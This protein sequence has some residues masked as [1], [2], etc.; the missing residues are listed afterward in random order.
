M[1]CVTKMAN[2]WQNAVSKCKTLKKKTTKSWRILVIRSLSLS[3]TCFGHSF[4]SRL[5]WQPA[6]CRGRRE[7]RRRGA[8]VDEEK[9]KSSMRCSISLRW[10]GGSISANVIWHS[11]QRRLHG[12]DDSAK[13]CLWRLHAWRCW[14]VIWS[15]HAKRGRLGRVGWQTG[16]SQSAKSDTQ[17]A[18]AEGASAGTTKHLYLLKDSTVAPQPE[19][20]SSRVWILWRR[21]LTERRRKNTEPT[22]SI[23]WNVSDAQQNSSRSKFILQNAW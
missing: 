15:S 6:R 23:R 10:G 21:W 9:K 4:S 16:S 19:K 7:T 2:V 8:M 14:A 20:H 1:F 3:S 17:A 12:A 5:S 22:P 13:P 18:A 11:T